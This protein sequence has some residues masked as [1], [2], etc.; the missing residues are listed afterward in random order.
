MFDTIY[1]S[2]TAVLNDPTPIVYTKV[3]STNQEGLMSSYDMVSSLYMQGHALPRRACRCM[4]VETMSFVCEL[5]H[6]ED[7]GQYCNLMQVC[8][9]GER[10]VVS[11][12]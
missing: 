3:D 10:Y 1:Q 9:T 5:E 8:K 12:V 4:P 11:C 2:L 7:K 6:K